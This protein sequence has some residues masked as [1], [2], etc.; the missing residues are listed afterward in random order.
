MLKIVQEISP[1]LEKFTEMGRKEVQ[2]NSTTGAAPH[3]TR[4]QGFSRESLE[5]RVQP[6]KTTLTY[7]NERPGILRGGFSESLH[8][9]KVDKVNTVM[10]PCFRSTESI[11]H[12]DVQQEV[13][14]VLGKPQCQHCFCTR[15]DSTEFGTLGQGDQSLQEETCTVS[16]GSNSQQDC[17]VDCNVNARR[18]RI[19]PRALH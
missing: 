1:K 3:D 15:P 4:T 8:L 17:D 10:A 19:I 5:W 6:Q 16:D 7:W 18:P 9:V 12:R 2:R 13:D 14:L 11:A